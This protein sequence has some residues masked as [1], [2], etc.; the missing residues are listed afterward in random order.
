M[1]VSPM[2]TRFP[3]FVGV[4]EYLHT[5][6]LA[7]FCEDVHKRLRGQV[8]CHLEASL[9][10]CPPTY[11]TSIWMILRESKSCAAHKAL[12]MVPTAW[13]A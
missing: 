1:L 6:L 12:C 13:A 10:A 2:Y 4:K 3:A 9:S 5:S 11:P 8:E 7:E